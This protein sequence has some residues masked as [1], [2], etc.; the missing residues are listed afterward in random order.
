[1]LIK[2]YFGKKHWCIATQS[3]DKEKIEK[4]GEIIDE[5]K[6]SD[7]VFTEKQEVFMKLILDRLKKGER[8]NLLFSGL[9]GTGKTYSS[10][11]IACETQKPF[12]YLNGAMSKRKIINLMLSAKD[13]AIILIDEIH[14]LPEKVA[15]II[16]SAIQDNEIYDDGKRH[17]LNNITF[18]GTTTEPESLPKPLQDR[19]MRIEFDEPDEQTLTKILKKMGLNDKC[20]N[21]MINYTLNIRVLKKIIEYT[22][23]Y[24]EKN[25]K[26]LI[27]VFRLMKINVYSG[28][29][30]EQEKYINHLKS[31]K[32]ASLRNLSLVLRRSENYIKLDIEP[33]LIRKQMIIISSRGRE[34]NPELRD[35]SY[36]ELEKVSETKS[37]V[38]SETKTL[39]EIEMAHRYLKENPEIKKKFGKRYLELVNFIANKITEG[40]SPNEI[41]I[42]S[43]GNDV[44]IEKSYES[45][46]LEEL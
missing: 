22:E 33:D 28:L 4:I 6:F 13:N 36:D 42:E 9:A 35:Y 44:P 45:N 39:D 21:L 34:L 31:T 10:K 24:G 8:R 40:I 30:D 3:Y 32:K 5:P 38:M 1:M 18:I 12:L 29:S 41:D 15:E 14:N 19:F 46:Y 43:F 25:E 37:N 27:K 20:I 23:L 11:M 2:D 16:Y 26:N 17:Q 7:V